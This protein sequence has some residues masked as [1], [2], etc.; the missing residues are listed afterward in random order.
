MPVASQVPVRKASRTGSSI[1]TATGA[2]STRSVRSDSDS[3]NRVDGAA[4]TN[5]INRSTSSCEALTQGNPMASELPRKISEN[6]SP[7]QASI[8]HRF[9]ACGACSRDD[10]D[11][12]LSLASRM[13]AC[14]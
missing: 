6:D 11:P 3:V 10:P 2:S 1:T 4:S 7:T 13:R 14:R 12:K 8:P 5:R 9:S